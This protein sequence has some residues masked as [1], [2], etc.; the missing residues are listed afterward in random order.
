MP[1]STESGETNEK[2]DG[3]RR[4]RLEIPGPGLELAT[5]IQF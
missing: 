3:G 4:R 1:T 2:I 5:Q